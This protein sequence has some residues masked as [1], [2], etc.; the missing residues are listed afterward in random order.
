MNYESTP[1]RSIDRQSNAA[2]D[3]AELLHKLIPE[4][5]NH[6]KML[7]RARNRIPALVSAERLYAARREVVALVKELQEINR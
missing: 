5:R 4:A 1:I 7:V 2:E 6:W 3:R